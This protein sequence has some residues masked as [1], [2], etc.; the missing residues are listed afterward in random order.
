MNFVWRVSLGSLEKVFLK[1]ASRVTPLFNSSSKDLKILVNPNDLEDSCES[2]MI[3][4]F[5]FEDLTLKSKTK[6]SEWIWQVSGLQNS[7][8]YISLLALAVGAQNV[9]RDIFAKQK[10]L[11]SNR[12]ID[13][14]LYFL[15]SCLV[16]KIRKRLIFG[17]RIAILFLLVEIIG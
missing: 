5:H 2:K 6:W 12:S 7:F 15:V 17:N 3:F 16:P 11:N 8:R 1:V 13:W 9:Y 14:V 10:C 4:F